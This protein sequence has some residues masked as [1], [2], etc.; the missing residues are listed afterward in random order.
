MPTAEDFFVLAGEGVAEEKEDFVA[1]FDSLPWWTVLKPSSVA[2]FSSRPGVA[3]VQALAPISAS[4]A[5]AHSSPGVQVGP[6]PGGG[7]RAFVVVGAI[8]TVLSKSQKLSFFSPS[9]SANRPASPAAGACVVCHTAQQPLKTFGE[10]RRK[11]QDLEI[12]P[13]QVGEGVLSGDSSPVAG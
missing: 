8:T 10:G 13:D 7:D 3:K 12:G 4:T 9:P 5:A 1:L 6:N 2:R 11:T